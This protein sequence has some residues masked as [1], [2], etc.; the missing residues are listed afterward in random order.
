M[1]DIGG[2]LCPAV[3]SLRRKESPTTNDTQGQRRTSTYACTVHTHIQIYAC[4]YIYVHVLH[5]YTYTYRMC[6]VTAWVNDGITSKREGE[7]TFEN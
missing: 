3:W 5:T 6:P 1:T 7:N 2:I 4:I